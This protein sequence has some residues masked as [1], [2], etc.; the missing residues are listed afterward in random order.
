MRPQ[1]A[2]PRMSRIQPLFRRLHHPI[3]LCKHLRGRRH[4]FSPLFGSFS[5]QSGMTSITGSV[6]LLPFPSHWSDERTTR[7]VLH[8]H[9]ARTRR[10][11]L[12]CARARSCP[13]RRPL[14]V[15]M[16]APDCACY[17]SRAA[18]RVGAEVRHWDDDGAHATSFMYA[19]SSLLVEPE[20]T[21]RHLGT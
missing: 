18:V 9:R 14:L 20:L 12:G 8:I 7:R 21:R 16:G 6:R 13:S 11:C 19:S 5:G 17:A 1:L 10:A 4:L 2:C 15:Y 3:S